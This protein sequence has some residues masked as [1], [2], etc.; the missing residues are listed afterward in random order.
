MAHQMK[1]F[2]TYLRIS[3][4]ICQVKPQQELTSKFQLNK[5]FKT[6]KIL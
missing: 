2:F 6:T 4:A 3:S 1:S 5:A